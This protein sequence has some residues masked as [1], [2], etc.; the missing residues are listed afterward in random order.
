MKEGV[1]AR[2]ERYRGDVRKGEESRQRLH[3]LLPEDLGPIVY[4][5]MGSIQYAYLGDTTR[6]HGQW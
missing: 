2:A 5:H 4:A 6:M 3:R 1:P